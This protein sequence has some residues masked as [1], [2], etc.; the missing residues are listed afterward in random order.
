[1]AIDSRSII[2]IICDNN[3]IIFAV[4]SAMI[5]TLNSYSQSSVTAIPVIIKTIHTRHDIKVVGT[6]N[7][8]EHKEIRIIKW[9]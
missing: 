4:Q 2:Q 7:L 3:E 6:I 9:I 8:L 1:M 5:N